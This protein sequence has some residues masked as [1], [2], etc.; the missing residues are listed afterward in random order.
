MNAFVAGGIKSGIG[1]WRHERWRT[2]CALSPWLSSLSGIRWIDLCNRHEQLEPGDCHDARVC[3]WVD[4]SFLT[5]AK[6]FPRVGARLF[7]HCFAEWPFHDGPAP[8]ARSR[9][10][11]IS[12][13]LPV[14]GRDRLST[15][16]AV[17]DSLFGQRHAA[18]EYIVVEQSAEPH[19]RDLVPPGVRY[20]QIPVSE[21]E[22]FNKSACL[23]EGVRQASADLVLLHDAD[24]MVPC[25]YAARILSLVTG[26]GVEAVR[27]IRLLFHLDEDATREWVRARI[28]P[29][30]VGFVQQNNPGLSTAVLRRVYWEIGGHD[31]RFIGWGGE[32]LEFLDRLSCRRLFK[33]AYAPAVHLWHPPAPKKASGDRN[34][35]LLSEMRRVPPRDRISELIDRN[36]SA[37]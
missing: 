27:P 26:Q 12:I 19:F 22:G 6:R 37:S 15:F 2:E 21:A 4:S 29:R 30:Q 10:P 36:A 31:E 7:D 35:S 5:V 18:C 11:D 34:T 16:P 32:D 25:D 17:L 13:I 9:R 3:S 14:G 1:C 33:G 24:V 8:Q 28:A 20:V 23:N